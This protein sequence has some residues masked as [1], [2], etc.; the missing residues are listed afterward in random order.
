MRPCSSTISIGDFSKLL[1]KDS[2]YSNSNL[3]YEIC[4]E[5]WPEGA[6]V[7]GKMFFNDFSTQVIL[8]VLFILNPLIKFHLRRLALLFPLD[9]FAVGPDLSEWWYENKQEQLRFAK[10]TSRTHLNLREVK[11]FFYKK[12]HSTAM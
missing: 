9:Y 12:Q 7:A 3:I 1:A 10:E 6:H 2:L 5:N 4:D 11:R 8:N